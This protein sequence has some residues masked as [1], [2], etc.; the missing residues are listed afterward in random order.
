MLRILLLLLISVP[1][2]AQTDS[3]RYDKWIAWVT[4][5]SAVHAIHPALE[6]GAEYNPGKLWAYSLNYGIRSMS[7]KDLHYDDQSHQYMRLGFKRYFAPKFNSGYIMPELGLFHISHKGLHGDITWQEKDR[8]A[9]Q[10]DARIHDFYVK[11]GGLLG[12]KM[13]AGGLRFDLFIG[14]GARFTFRHHTL[15][16]IKENNEEWWMYEH[17]GFEMP[18]DRINLSTPRGWT[19]YRPLYYLSLGL[20]LGIGLRP[21]R[22]PVENLLTSP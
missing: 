22:T 15:L 3:L 4:P 16:N 9:S 20:R 13:K 7:G 12:R 2:T 11:A 5:T 17:S 18:F 1:L 10:A 8:P 19:S 14:G 21:V 6:I